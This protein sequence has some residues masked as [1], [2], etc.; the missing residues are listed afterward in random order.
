[1]TKVSR[2]QFRVI[3]YSMKISNITLKDIQLI[4]ISRFNG[5]HQKFKIL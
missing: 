4:N 2:S 3:A 1:M 5:T